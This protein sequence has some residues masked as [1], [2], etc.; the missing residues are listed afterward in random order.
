MTAPVADAQLWRDSGVPL[1]RQIAQRLR[2]EIGTTPDS[3]RPLFTE[4][5]LSLRFGVHRMT[6]RQALRELEQD[7]LIVRHR[8]VGTFRAPRKLRGEPIYLE[9]FMDHWAMQG[10]AVSAE[11]LSIQD[12]F[13]DARVA[14]S[15]GLYD[16]LPVVHVQRRRSVDDQPLVIDHI[17]L[18][19]STGHA[20]ERD[21]LLRLT[22][23]RAI[24]L[25]TGHTATSAE[26]EI[27]ATIADGE[28]ATLLRIAPGS[29]LFRRHIVL[30]DEL[31]R[32]LSY[33][34]SLYRADLYT[35]TLTVPLESERAYSPDQ[36]SS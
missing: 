24:R 17:F 10:R 34:W 8:G 16:D 20:L 13:P 9:S 30:L 2:R 7:G 33:G 18:P 19:G 6:V 11:I 32:P 1:Y 36:V 28:W 29:P 27:E 14:R 15:L 5:A 21:D 4:E 12:T 26:L 35:Y 25:R 3:D 23:H 31:R 22:L